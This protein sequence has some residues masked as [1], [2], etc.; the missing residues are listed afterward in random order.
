MLVIS[1]RVGQRLR[2]RARADVDVWISI[3][4]VDRGKIR[5]GIHAPRDVEV[6]REELVPVLPPGESEAP[7]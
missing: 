4:D 3:Q 6:L 1:R 2:I 7:S 5:L